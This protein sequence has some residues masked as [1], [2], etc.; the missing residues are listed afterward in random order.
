MKSGVQRS[1][2][3]LADVDDDDEVNARCDNSSSSSGG[4]GS[5]RI[6]VTQSTDA[7]TGLRFNG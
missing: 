2:W 5:V 3:R 7:P 1:A 4:G 6:S